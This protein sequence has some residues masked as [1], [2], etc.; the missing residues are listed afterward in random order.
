MID[1]RGR[2]PETPPGFDHSPDIA[3]ARARIQARAAAGKLLRASDFPALWLAHK[4]VF[5]AAQRDKCAYC[6]TESAAAQF[7]TIDHYRPKTSIVDRASGNRGR[8]RRPGYYWLAYD[9]QNW[10]YVCQVCNHAKGEQFPLRRRR[11]VRPGAE[12]D[13]RPLLLNPYDTDPA[14]HLRFDARGGVRGLTPEGRRTIEVCRLERIHLVRKRER[15]ARAL[16]T[17]FDTYHLVARARPGSAAEFLE[18]LTR[19]TRADAEYA[20]MARDLLGQWLSAG[21]QRR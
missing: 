15:S 10:L 3:R 19:S 12:R 20:G 5:A 17:M 18:L 9:W 1:L 6:E 13:E 8:R 2:R 4:D 14:P 16:R 7:G 11:R 21:A